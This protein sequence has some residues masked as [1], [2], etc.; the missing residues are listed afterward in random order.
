MRGATNPA[1]EMKFSEWTSL[2]YHLAWAYEDSVWPAARVGHYSNMSTS[3]WLVRRGSVTVTTDGQ[4]TH[5]TPGQWVF[6]AS[7]SRHQEFSADARILSIHFDFTW[8]GGEQV[9][10]RP[11]NLLL[12]ADDFPQLGETARKIT[13][14][15]KREFP[16]AHA[17]L[18]RE[19]CTM[20][21]FL[22]VQSFLPDW[23]AAYLGALASFGVH[24]R[25]MRVQDGRILRALV[26]LDQQSLSSA[27]S[28]ADLAEHA[29][30]SRSRLDSLFV[31]A[32][33]VTPRAYLDRRRLDEASKLL[34]H[35]GSSIKE[36]AMGLGFRHASHFSLWF[37]RHRKASPQSFR[38]SREPV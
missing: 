5:A 8:P 18:T 35:T 26:W 24:P 1:P 19:P 9:I 32:M 16:H 7:P 15:V 11:R 12:K 23:L 37:R 30:L 27:Y 3:C 10:Q 20:E 22:S 36:I 17:F 28:A 25:R 6:V 2:R 33:G 38:Q 31:E 14:M 21:R 13:Q 4:K 34:L 29:G